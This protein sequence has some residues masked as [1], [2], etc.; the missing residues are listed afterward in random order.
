VTSSMHPEPAR[1]VAR[2]EEA[3]DVVTLTL[4]TSPARALRPGQ[5]NML[6]A[7]GVG[8]VPLS[9]SGDPARGDLA[10]HTI[11]AV[12]AVTRALC[13]ARPDDVLGVRGPYGTP[14]PL[15]ALTGADLLV[16]AGGLG[17]APLRSA[18]YQALAGRS[19]YGRIRVLVGARSP[20]DILF[21][22]ELEGWQRRHDVDVLV[23]VDHA[24]ASW[25]GHVG[26]V[27]A[28]LSRLD[29]GP[30]T[31]ALVCGPEVM[32]RFTVRELG[33]R[34]IA[35][36]RMFLAMER[37][38]KCALGFCGHCQLGPSFVCRDGPVI[39]CDRLGSWLWLKEG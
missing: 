14:W 4:A 5:F 32:M 33:R 29:L 18:V 11:R 31:A 1:V 35:D 19:S 27:T 20:A 6:Y 24:E 2:H 22:A 16:V 13:R 9:T 39:R 23:T 7:F 10:V 38:M 8:E 37:N 17:L 21:R 28:L 15:E 34:G 25:Q 3:A 36:D 30:A 26:V 12:G